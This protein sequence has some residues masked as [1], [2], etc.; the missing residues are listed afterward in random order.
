MIHP[1]GQREFRQHLGL[2]LLHRHRQ[3][4]PQLVRT[5]LGQ[6][7]ILAVLDQHLRVQLV[8]VESILAGEQPTVLVQNLEPD[9]RVLLV[10]CITLSL[11]SRETLVMDHQLKVARQQR[12]ENVQVLA[13][14]VVQVQLGRR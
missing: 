8:E 2:E 1:G 6:D 14:N 4:S 12:L 3:Y 11:Q 5:H 10:L 9:T 13:N 7:N